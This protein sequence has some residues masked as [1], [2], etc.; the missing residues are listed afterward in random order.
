MQNYFKLFDL[1][2]QYNIDLL[3]LDSKYFALLAKYHPD[4]A[5][6]TEEK[7]KF[8]TLSSVINNGYKI[9]MD[10]FERAAHILELHEINIK[11]DSI[12]HK[13]P[14]DILEE[15]LEMKE[16]LEYGNRN[17]KQAM[18]AARLDKR[19]IIISELLNLFAIK[20]YKAAAIKSMMLRYY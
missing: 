10:D 2:E 1:Q 3:L 11:N 14:F 15:I 5:S 6:G 9:L 16:K 20:D 19:K 7:Y 17:E 13:L 18:L 4:K 8:S 12:A